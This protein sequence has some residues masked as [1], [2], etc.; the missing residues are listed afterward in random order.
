M[1][2]KGILQLSGTPVDLLQW[3]SNNIG[4]SRCRELWGTTKETES[5]PEK[6][7]L[8]QELQWPPKNCPQATTLA[9]QHRGNSSLEQAL[10]LSSPL[11]STLHLPFSLDWE[12]AEAW[13]IFCYDF[14]DFTFNA[15][16]VFL[17][18][19]HQD[20]YCIN[21]LLALLP[22]C[23]CWRYLPGSCI[24]LTKATHPAT[25]SPVL[26]VP[27]YSMLRNRPWVN[28]L[29]IKKL[30]VFH[31]GEITPVSAKD[32]VSTVSESQLKPC[33]EGTN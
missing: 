24:V 9:G 16:T 30:P 27:L 22:W 11:L 14:Y 2:R 3:F 31:N 20:S 19:F 33:C 5:K 7:T 12:F 18:I 10:H 15:R 21:K 25:K 32:M 4:K 29:N 28:H 23:S 17:F 26:S 8:I 1:E 13:V 6:G